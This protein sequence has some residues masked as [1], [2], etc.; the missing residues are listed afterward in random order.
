MPHDLEPARYILQHLGH[1]LAHP[2]QLLGPTAWAGAG[3]RLVRLGDARQMLGELSARLGNGHGR[4]IGCGRV[5]RHRHVGR[6]VRRRRL[7]LLE[8][9]LELCDLTRD[10]LR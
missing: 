8:L 10:A 9:Q 5:W 1:I 3:R 2:A 6:G 7:D 4:H